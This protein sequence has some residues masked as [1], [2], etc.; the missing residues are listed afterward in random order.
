MPREKN[1]ALRLLVPLLVLAF[2]GVVV[3]S[4]F[5]T[6]SSGPLGGQTTQPSPEAESTESDQID[7]DQ[8][9]PDQADA[10]QPPAGQ[11]DTGQP[12][13]EAAPDSQR[14]QPASA[15][16]DAGAPDDSDA[17]SSAA[18][19][20][21]SPDT[22]S[23]DRLDTRYYPPQ[24]APKP[25]GSL[26][27]DS[28]YELQ[29]GFTFT[30]AGVEAITLTNHKKTYKG[31]EPYVLQQRAMAANYA[32]A[33]L[34]ARGVEI[35]G[36]FIDLFSADE[37]AVRWRETGPGAFET[38]IETGDG[39]P[40]ARIEKRY[41]VRPGSFELDVNQSL[42]N[43][44]DRPLSVRW[45][46]YGP[47]DLPQGPVGYGGD[48]RRIRFAHT[49][50]P[51]QD[52]TGQFVQTSDFLGRAKAL[53]QID[54]RGEPVLLW[55]TD[56]SKKQQQSLIWAAMTNRYFTFAVHPQVDVDQWSSRQQIDK[57]F[58]QARE[59]YAVALGG[60]RNRSLVLQLNGP[61]EH[62]APRESLGLSIGAYA[63]PI[64]RRTLGTEPV[65]QALRLDKLVIYNFGGP[66]AFCTFQPLA[67]LLIW[68]LSILHDH[69][70][71]DWAIAIMI[72]VVVVRGILHPVTKKSQISIQRFSKQ[73]QALAPKQQKL[74]EKYKDDPKRMQQEMTKL[75]REEGISFTGA[76]GCLPMFLQSPIWIALYAMLYFAFDLRHEEAF[77]GFFQV[78]T[79]GNWAF[80][81]D[82]SAPDRFIDFGRTLVTIPLLGE[83]S[84]I[85]VL[86]LLL[87]V[88]F[89][90]QQ[91][92]MTPPPT[93]QLTPEQQTQQKMMK[94]MLVGMF[95]IIMYNAPSGLAVY[96]ITNSTLGIAESRYIRAH[97]DQMDLEPQK[98]TPG[99]KKTKKKVA[100]T[101]AGAPFK[102][103]ARDR[104]GS[105]Y[106]HRG[107][108]KK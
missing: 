80:L 28:G 92:Y 98:P 10:D 46:Q 21:E 93:T 24:P 71:F 20:G 12:D 6:S 74:R 85:N 107:R 96:F 64:S 84:S 17:D 83:I 36:L 40:I 49:L 67:R 87:G 9:D 70:V 81:A 57:T 7:P 34:A 69:I 22:Q 26:D 35:N 42:E 32:V 59:I 61:T 106:K 91:K 86:P 94:I 52:P 38:V 55:P 30:G 65:Y 73:M 51:E 8:A 66:C 11:P 76:L 88:V 2:G 105:P 53:D 47:V 99:K 31:S 75:M 50:G 102:S 25:I 101:A 29:I 79:G 45:L 62:L 54:S 5:V 27:P 108:K 39:E 43:L 63:G 4:V 3:M 15:Q 14:D 56:Q 58:G 95:P 18:S 68:F 89:F 72:L 100:N 90:I 103:K 60:P 82:L 104:D 1:K 16:S 44:T 23:F 97:I 78:I 13:A 41:I 33:S 77:F 37:D 19:G 48:K